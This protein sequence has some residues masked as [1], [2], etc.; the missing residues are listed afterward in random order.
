MF[1]F[2][3]KV[4]SEY[5]S[6][7]VREGERRV[8]IFE[9]GFDYERWTRT[10]GKMKQVIEFGIIQLLKVVHLTLCVN[11]AGTTIE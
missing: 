1:R 11:T 7:S 6:V 2:L 3:G 5:I 10:F 9:N 8:S 4:V